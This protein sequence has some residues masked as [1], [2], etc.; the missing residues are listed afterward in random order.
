MVLKELESGTH[1]DRN[2]ATDA[3]LWLKRYVNMKD[4]YCGYRVK[5]EKSGEKRRE[6]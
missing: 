5:D 1:N 6:R 2:S 3:L 4:G